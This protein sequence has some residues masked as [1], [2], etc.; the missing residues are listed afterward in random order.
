MSGNAEKIIELDR[1][2][3]AA[4]AEKDVAKLDRI[5]ADDLIYTHS[6]ARVDTKKTLIGAMELGDY[7]LYG[8]GAVGRRGAGSW[9]CRRAH[10]CRGDQRQ[11]RWRAQFVPSAVC[12]CL[13]QPRRAVA[14]GDVAE[15][16]A[17]VEGD[18]AWPRPRRR[19]LCP[20][21]SR[22][23]TICALVWH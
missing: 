16:K 7:R 3:M 12:R 2:R 8:R 23:S 1:Q 15:H 18:Q 17:G 9:R 13:C 4:M 10:G 6:S 21:R 19:S 11:E 22:R 5:I 20:F 14:D